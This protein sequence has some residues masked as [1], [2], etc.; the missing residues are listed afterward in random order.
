MKSSYNVELFNKVIL[1]V[2]YKQKLYNYLY[3]YHER[4]PSKFYYFQ[5]INQRN[6]S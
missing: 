6:S 1:L 5:Y 4:F 2:I 3:N